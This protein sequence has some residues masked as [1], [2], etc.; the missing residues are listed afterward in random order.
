MAR[1]DYSG[2]SQLV[3]MLYE[4]EGDH[5]NLA[6]TVGSLLVPF[7]TTLLP[8]GLFEDLRSYIGDEIMGRGIRM[9]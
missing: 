3:S 2:I 5:A 6:Q 1:S 4:F 8:R 9:P 7:E